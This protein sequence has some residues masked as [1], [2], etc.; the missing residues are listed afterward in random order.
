MIPL[1]AAPTGL[2]IF[3]HA[4]P[5]A[6]R[7]FSPLTLGYV[8]TAPSEPLPLRGFVMV[9]SLNPGLCSDG[10][11]RASAPAGL[12][13][14]FIPYPWAMLLRL[15][16][17]LCPCGAVDAVIDLGCDL[18][19]PLL[20]CRGGWYIFFVKCRNEIKILLEIFRLMRYNAPHAPQGQ[21]P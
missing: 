3:F 16:Q 2:S 6:A 1:S 19:A 14:G 11:F 15:L 18:A 4:I 13:K 5:R 9:L 20:L 10:S 7:T 17:S 8:L 21:R 12:C